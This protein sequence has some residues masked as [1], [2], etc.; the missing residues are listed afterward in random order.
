MTPPDLRNPE[1][2]RR[3]A[4]AQRVADAHRAIDG[5]ALLAFVSGSVVEE[6]A[7]TRSDV[8]MS[9]VLDPLP[10]EAALQAACARAGGTPWFWQA[11]TLGEG[12][13]VVA[14]RIDG[15]EV[16]IG[17]S[18]SATLNGHIDEVL[19]EQK[20]DTMMHKLAEGV[21]KAEP[22]AGADRLRA[23]QQRLAVF[24]P[25]LGDAMIAHHLTLGVPWRA[26]SQLLHRDSPLWCRELIVNACYG[27]VGTLAGLN[28]RYWTRFQF[29]RNAKFAASL[30]LAPPDL[31]ARIEALLEAPPRAAFDAL[32]A[33]EGEVL[34]LLAAHRPA[35]DTSA[36]QRRRGDYR[37]A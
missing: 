17:Y 34:V 28:Q 15:I 10:D 18:D 31:A 35:V 16:Q 9:V 29:K 3:R 19:V 37:P 8:D 27:L 2:D 13:L 14:F 5:A 7:D 25:A 30:A 23:L 12:G 36:V 4:I 1:S 11:G 32:H 20:A 6:L 26:A 24:P 33:L 21:A 22:L